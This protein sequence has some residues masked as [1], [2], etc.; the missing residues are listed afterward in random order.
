M[1][2]RLLLVAS[3]LAC[4]NAAHVGALGRPFQY[5]CL[6]GGTPPPQKLVLRDADAGGIPNKYVGEFFPVVT[7]ADAEAHR[8]AAK[9]G[10]TITYVFQSIDGFAI[11]LDDSKAP[12]LAAE[13]EICILEQDAIA[14][15]DNGDH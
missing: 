15:P 8:L 10:G 9:H 14:Y 3:V 5:S 7:D 11:D 12:A 6:D 4:T 13:A 2:L 1:R